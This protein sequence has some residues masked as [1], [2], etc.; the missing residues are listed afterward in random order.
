MALCAVSGFSQATSATATVITAESYFQTPPTWQ[1][2]C[3]LSA[4]GQV[5]TPCAT[6]LTDV[7]WFRFTIPAGTQ[8]C[9][10]KISVIPSGFDA[11][12]DIFDNALAYKQCIN[13]AGNNAAEY[14]KTNPNTP[15]FFTIANGVNYYFRVS[16][17]TDVN[18]L[19]F[20]VGL[21]YYAA[22]Q[23]APSG[24]PNPS[25]DT[26]LPGYKVTD[27]MVRTT[28]TSTEESL[29]QATRWRFV[30]TTTP[31]AA[32]CTITQNGTYP[33]AQP[34]DAS[35]VC[36]NRSYNVYVELK[37]DDWWC[38]ACIVRTINMETQPTASILTTQCSV[39]NLNG[40]LSA[41]YLGPTYTLQWE[42]SLNGSVVSTFTSPV[43]LALCYLNSVP[44]LRYNRTYSVRVRASYCGQWG[45]WSSPTCIITSSMPFTQL[46]PGFCGATVGVFSQISCSP[47]TGAN[48]YTWQLAEVNPAQPLVPIAPAR[49][50]CTPNIYLGI[51]GIVQ[52]GKTYRVGIKPA[53]TSSTYSCTG[54]LSS[55]TSYQE[56]DYGNFCT[57]TIPG[58]MATLPADNYSPFEATAMPIQK[59]LEVLSQDGASKLIT[60]KFGDGITTTTSL[61]TIYNL[62]GQEVNRQTIFPGG[63]GTYYQLS[64]PDHLPSGIYMISI[65]NADK[66]MTDKIFIP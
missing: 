45:D 48:Q 19:C 40:S 11:V 66:T 43:G 64:L 12:V 49:V 5:S 63:S 42:F 9:A 51:G 50:I 31:A 57:I 41:T 30:D 33:I 21:E 1:N 16:S 35:C 27:S 39:V 46:T 28:F 6:N 7:Y 26:G 47:V 25:P 54:Q 10:V 61:M 37:I 60:L 34:R 20:Q 3:L 29:I 14:L 59:D 38:G 55:C 53:L 18:A 65:K 58:G 13:S 56:G 22:G 62:S 52:A 32:G 2:Y 24:A 23:L 4:T 44:C 36:Y 17:T 15:D 8:T